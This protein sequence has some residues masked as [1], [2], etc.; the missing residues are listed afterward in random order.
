[1]DDLV[2]NQV[3]AAAAGAER[4]RSRAL[5]WTARGLSG[6]L[7]AFLVA[8]AAGK[9]LA[10]G[11]VLE[12]SLQLGYSAD[13]VRPMGAL[14]LASTLLYALPRTQFLGALLLTAYLGGATASMVRVGSLAWCPVLMGSLIWITYLIRSPELCRLLLPTPHR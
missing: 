5:L 10:V 4:P 9:L 8:D 3:T 13:V 12:A 14:L 2:M 11:A 1:M 7:V 6:L